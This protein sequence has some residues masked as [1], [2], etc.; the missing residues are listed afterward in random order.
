MFDRG[1]A[2]D[3]IVTDIASLVRPKYPVQSAL[4]PIAGTITPLSHN[5]LCCV[6]SKQTS[7]SGFVTSLALLHGI[8]SEITNLP[9]ELWSF[10]RCGRNVLS[11]L[12]LTETEN[13]RSLDWPQARIFIKW[14]IVN[15]PFLPRAKPKLWVAGLV[16][17]AGFRRLRPFFC[18]KLSRLNL[19]RRRSHILT[20]VD[21]RQSLRSSLRAVC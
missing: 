12:L 16:S 11:R 13:L 18:R 9:K 17:I 8:D 5:A 19:Q 3:V 10:H 6:R 4:G 2:T 14:S 1:I 7:S 20:V 21:T 15:E